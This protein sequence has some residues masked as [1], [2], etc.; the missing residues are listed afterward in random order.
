MG[1]VCCFQT[2]CVAQCRMPSEIFVELTLGSLT[3]DYL[4]GITPT[5][6]AS[7]AAAID[8]TYSLTPNVYIAGTQR[9]AFSYTPPY[10]FPYTALLLV[11][12]CNAPFSPYTAVTFDMDL[13]YSG[14]TN[15]EIRF[16][17]LQPNAG[18]NIPKTTLPTITDYCA[19]SGFST[20]TSTTLRSLPDTTCGQNPTAAHR[21]ADF[22]LDVTF[23]L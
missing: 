13:C 21:Y 12:Y 6:I 16:L 8:G 2:P 9:Y 11:W 4:W 14:S 15:E 19:G 20:S 5:E 3:A 18:I 7:I 23:S 17:R 10:Q 1:C 22:D